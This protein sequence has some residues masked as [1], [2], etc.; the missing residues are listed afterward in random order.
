MQQLIV[1]MPL[2]ER[3]TVSACAYNA[4]QKCHAKA[5]TVGDG[6]FPGCDTFFASPVHSRRQNEAGVG[7]CKVDQ[8]RYNSDFECAADFISVGQKSGKVHCL[9]YKR[10]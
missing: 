5:I 4:E 10:R 2:V 7:A 9:T 8:C 3:C 6:A 1:D